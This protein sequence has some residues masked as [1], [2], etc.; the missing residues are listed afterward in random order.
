MTKRLRRDFLK[1]CGMVVAGLAGPTPPLFA[2]QPHMVFPA[3]PRDRLGVASYPFRAQF[4]TAH[5]WERDHSLPTMDLKE[6]AT[7]VVE[8]FRIRNI[9]PLDAHFR[10]LDAAYLEDLRN[11]WE[12]AGVKV[13]NI[14]V[15]GHYSFYDPDASRRARAVD[16]ARR[17]VDVAVKVGSPSIR[18]HIAGVRGMRPDVGRAA[19]S[20]R[21][22][23]DYGAEKDVQI[24]LE[25]D[26]LV[27]EDAFF[28]VQV[29]ERVAH[30]YL[31]ALPDFG[32]S[33]M[34]GDAEF[35]Y[36]AVAAMFQHAYNISHCKDGEVNGRGEFV[37]VDLARTFAIAKA[38]GY[39]GYFS[40]E[41]EGKGSPYDGTGRLIAESLKY[42]SS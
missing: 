15:G 29:I 17:W 1:R 3:Q 6:F 2:S 9:E 27:T 26:D 39:R 23:A 8:R 4:H 11:A 10:S 24:N 19:E 35:N 18:T 13:I 20:L 38:A 21:K 31:H 33:M 41:W 14:P 22:V 40:M 12:K 25:N 30:P 34:A 28:I 16:F 7:M 5:N 32:N 42:L 36:R 37:P